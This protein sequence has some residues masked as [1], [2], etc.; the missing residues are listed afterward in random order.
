[1]ELARHAIGEGRSRIGPG[2]A[3]RGAAVPA[4]A[5]SARPG[6]AEAVEPVRGVRRIVTLSAGWISLALGF[7]GVFLPLLPTTCFV[8]L[9]GVCFARTSPRAHRWLYHNR[10]FG[11][12]LTSYRDDRSVPMGLKV[13]SLTLLWLTV[14]GS[15][16]AIDGPGWVRLTLVAIAVAVT[17]HVVS[18]QTR[19]AARSRP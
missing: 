15:A 14:G 7:L 11:R 18:L 13:G 19:K 2:A 6:R 17:V 5:R 10:L 1:M 9:A 3:A 12:H 16:L 4:D 8:L